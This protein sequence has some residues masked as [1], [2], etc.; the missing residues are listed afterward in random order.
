M[1]LGLKGVDAIHALLFKSS[2]KSQEE[3]NELLELFLET[4]GDV[5]KEKEGKD[6]E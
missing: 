5:E 6:D 2:G 3:L 4:A 1:I